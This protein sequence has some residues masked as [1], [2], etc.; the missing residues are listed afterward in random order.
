MP[1]TPGRFM[2]LY[3]CTYAQGSLTPGVKDELAADITG[4]HSDINHVP[5]DYVNVVFAEMPPENV[6][7]GGR[8]GTPLLITGWARRGHPQDATTRLA[9]ALAEAASR[10]SGIPREHVMVVILDSPARSAVEAGRVLP[11]PGHEAEWLAAGR[12]GA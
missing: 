9:L 3:T 5:P 2:P 11:D 1:S 10:A 6:Y 4:I 12:A 7:V 8:P